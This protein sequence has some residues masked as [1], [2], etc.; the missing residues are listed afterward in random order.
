MS[1]TPP[2]LSA[3]YNKKGRGVVESRPRGE[4][5]VVGWLS[6]PPPAPPPTPSPPPIAGDRAEDLELGKGEG[7]PREG[8]KD[9]G[10]REGIIAAGLRG[11]GKFYFVEIPFM[12]MLL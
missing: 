3:P 11:K 9:A 5:W 8:A 2:S 4:W 7:G 1:P 6:H 10:P 12:M